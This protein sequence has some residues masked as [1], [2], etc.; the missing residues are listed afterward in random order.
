MRSVLLILCLAVTPVS[1]HAEPTV[2]V[3][4][5]N[6]AQEAAEGMARRGVLAHCRNRAGKVE[7]IGF[8]PVSSEAAIQNC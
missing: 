6:S 8:S 4:I 1:V 7:G 3:T 2:N 5:I